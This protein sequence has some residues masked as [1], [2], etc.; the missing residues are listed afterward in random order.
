MSN[1]SFT[2]RSR[3]GR[4][5]HNLVCLQAPD[6][7][8][9]RAAV[10]RALA[11]RN[12]TVTELPSDWSRPALDTRRRVQL[13]SES[14]GAATSPDQ[15][16]DVTLPDGPV[17]L[18]PRRRSD[19]LWKFAATLLMFAVVGAT[20]ILVLRNV[21]TDYHVMQPG[22]AGTP[23]VD[24]SATRLA[25][26]QSLTAIADST[27]AAADR[28]A[29]V[30]AGWWDP[31]AISNEIVVGNSPA[32][33]AAA[34]GS[35]WVANAGDGTV[36][37]IDAASGTVVATTTISSADGSRGSPQEIV[38]YNDQ[39][40]VANT[41]EGTL[42]R[43]DPATN[44]VV[45]TIALLNSDG[46]GTFNPSALFMDATGLWV[47]DDQVVASSSG[48]LLR[49]NPV[50]GAVLASVAVT[51]P[52]S[53]TSADGAIW[54]LSVKSY[55]SA[56][57]VRVDP[58]SN[59]VISEIAIAG[60]PS[61]VTTETGI[62]WVSDKHTG[63]ITRV[64][65]SSAAV[66]TIATGLGDTEFILG[67]PYG[68]WVAGWYVDTPAKAVVR[69]DTAT[70]QPSYAIDMNNGPIEGM[71]FLNNTIWVSHATGVVVQID[72]EQ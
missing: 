59:R 21:D 37:R 1:I 31:G 36:S 41:A 49:M 14:V 12:R 22:A 66:A 24:P 13:P 29:T 32:Q 50:T 48:R 11:E 52:S 64:D 2:P 25:A 17:L 5:L 45:K 71:A 3:A 51:R 61:Q 54:V 72:P 9:L 56:A 28:D 38:A 23:P 10:H 26:Q 16:T 34:A 27:T 63:S 39:I 15:P 67:T 7:L 47:A 43:I 68:V 55:E 62:I 6:D 70:Y 40:W 44:Q 30:R 19:E 35:V 65:P 53:I 57:I 42:V 33:I 4:K 60:S 58:I 20:L 69:I 8:D 46:S 18:P